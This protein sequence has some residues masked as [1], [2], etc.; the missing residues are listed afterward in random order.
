MNKRFTFS[1][2]GINAENKDEAIKT[3]KTLCEIFDLIP[4]IPEKGS[5][6]AGANIE[7]VLPAGHK[8]K[9]GHIAFYTDDIE[10]GIRE[11]EERGIALDHDAV[12]RNPDDN[13]IYLIYLKEE[14]CGFAVHLLGPKH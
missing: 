8:G 12:K 5:P 9:M 6:Y 2:V 4:K 14:F 11:L 7:L 1:H 13:S 10:A 3:A